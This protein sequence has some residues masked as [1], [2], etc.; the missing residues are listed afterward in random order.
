MIS[1]ALATLQNRR[2]DVSN[3]ES[4]TEKAAHE[5]VVGAFVALVADSAN[6]L[7]GLIS[8]AFRPCGAGPRTSPQRSHH[9]FG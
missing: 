8:Q 6:V 5:V 7:G 1:R 3:L 4:E 2:G 9:I